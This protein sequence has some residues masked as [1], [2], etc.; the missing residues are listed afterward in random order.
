MGMPG[1]SRREG[2]GERAVGLFQRVQPAGQVTQGGV[3]ETGPGLP[4]VL[5]ARRCLC[6]TSN[7]G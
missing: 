7:T 3:G 1:V 6:I 4:A 5:Q 2:A